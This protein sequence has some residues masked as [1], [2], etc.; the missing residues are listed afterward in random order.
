MTSAAPPA[1][2]CYMD[3]VGLPFPDR[4]T[5]AHVRREFKIPVSAEVRQKA[6]VAAGDEVDVDIK[7]HAEPREVPVPPDL[8]EALD[9]DA[10]ARRFFDGLSRSK[11]RRLVDPI[12]QAKTA[13]TRKRLS[14]AKP[15]QLP[16]ELAVALLPF[17]ER[18][19]RQR[20]PP[21]RDHLE[22]LPSATPGIEHA[23][24]VG[25]LLCIH[26]P[27]RSPWGKYGTSK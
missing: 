27:P 1:S 9:S 16:S 20:P 26:G 19:D 13:E 6:G 23:V 2:N 14:S 10:G 22:D 8:A 7:L 21:P 4:T 17:L 12:G 5:V 11:Q 18:H 25:A 3:R 15:L 24:R